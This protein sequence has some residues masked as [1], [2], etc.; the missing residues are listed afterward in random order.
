MHRARVFVLVLLVLPLLGLA[1]PP[2]PASANV[3][4]ADPFV[5]R[6]GKTY[7]AFATAARGAHVQVARSF[8]LTTW[9]A[10]PD[11][12]PELPKWAGRQASLTWAPSVLERDRRWILYYTAQDAAS[13]FQCISRATSARPEGPYADD[14]TKPFVCQLPLCG[15]IDPSPHI[16]ANGKPWL[17][18]KSD[19]NSTA[20]RGRARIWSQQLSPDGLALTGEPTPLLATDRS[21]EHPLIEGP[22][23]FRS[24]TQ[25]HLLYSGGWYESAQYAVGWA[26][27]DGPA[28][29]CKKM[30]LDAPL[31]KSTS[32]LLGPGGQELFDDAD[33]RLW[34]AYHAWTAP[35]ATYAAGGARA[36]R[37]SRVDLT[38]GT[39]VFSL[40]P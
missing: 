28:G 4:F 2:L 31:V 35:N 20:C 6:D 39:P 24:G 16:D 19:E 7:Y 10:L 26:T 37:F 36:L 12:L 8:D 17:L 32:T 29:P 23:M 22:S 3:D 27:C 14:S 40:T 21:W 9:T 38:S 1:E 13:G 11:A 18:W 15:S 25:T 30:T 5:L 34:M 33:G